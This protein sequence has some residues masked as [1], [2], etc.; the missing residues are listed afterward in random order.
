MLEFIPAQ[1]I[2]Y[3]LIFSHLSPSDLFS[4]R[5]CNTVLHHLVTSFLATNKRLDLAY[6]KRVTEAAF[7]I[8]TANAHSLRRLNVSGLKFLTDDLLRPVIVSNPHLVS[9]ELSECHHLTSGILHSLSTRTYQLERIILRDCHWVSRDS[10]E[11]HIAKQG[12]GQSECHQ[13][14]SL[15]L[16]CVRS[17]LTFLESFKSNLPFR[18]G[19]RQ[20][21]NPKD[22]FKLTPKSNLRE[23]DLTGCWELN[24][25]VIISLLSKFPSLRIIKLGKIYSITDHS[26]VGMARLCPGLHTLDITGCW[27]V[28]DQG[29]NTLAEYCKHLSELRVTDCRDVTEQSLTRFRQRG[30]KIDRMLD[31]VHFRMLRIRNELRHA[32]VQI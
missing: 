23:I 5:A 13:L 21:T 16:H 22:P 10:I 1:D 26:L 14:S 30:V 32:R 17:V 11:Y 31:P 19:S 20:N 8:L 24:D 4:V 15:S 28:T 7:L 25:D 12:V 3:P 29:V 6:N 9:V 18:V 27:R 2:L